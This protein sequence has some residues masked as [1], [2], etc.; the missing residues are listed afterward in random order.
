MLWCVGVDLY[1]LC[2]LWELVEG[3]CGDM[4]FFSVLM[5]LW[6]TWC[7]LRTLVI[8]LCDFRGIDSTC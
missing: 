3:V 6:C 8:V 1:I 7:G 2:V 4:V 5:V